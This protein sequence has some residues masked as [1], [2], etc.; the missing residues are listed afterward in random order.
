MPKRE[1]DLA[2]LDLDASKDAEFY[3]LRQ[4]DEMS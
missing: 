3:V 4:I 1:R 2:L